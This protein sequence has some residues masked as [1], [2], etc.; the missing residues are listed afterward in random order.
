MVAVK[1]KPPEQG[2]GQKIKKFGAI[3]WLKYILGHLGGAIAP[4][5]WL[6]LWYM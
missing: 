3:F 6:L 1:C 2:S 5:P 4:S